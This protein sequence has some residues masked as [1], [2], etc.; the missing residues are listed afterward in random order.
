MMPISPNDP[1]ALKAMVKAFCARA[2]DA[3]A[4]AERK[5]KELEA[6]GHADQPTGEHGRLP[7]AHDVRPQVGEDIPR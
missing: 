4:D 6:R 1:E 3:E 5:G 2:L 7:E